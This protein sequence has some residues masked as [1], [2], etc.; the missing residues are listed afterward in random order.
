[1]ILG[2][3]PA[4]QYNW[5]PLLRGTCCCTTVSFELFMVTSINVAGRRFGD[6]AVAS[7]THTV[8]CRAGCTSCPGRTPA[9]PRTGWSKT[10]PPLYH[11]WRRPAWLGWWSP[12]TSTPCQGISS[13]TLKQVYVTCMHTWALGGV[14]VRGDGPKTTPP[15]RNYLM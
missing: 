15:L 7:I 14:G 3:L 6:S 4:L 1:M 10:S 9:P 5:Y 8:S 2:R 13:T 12:S 11:C